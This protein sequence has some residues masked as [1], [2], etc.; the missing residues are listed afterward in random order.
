MDVNFWSA[1]FFGALAIC[2]FSAAVVILVCYRAPEYEPPADRRVVD[3]TWHMES[4][5]VVPPRQTI[6]DLLRREEL[7]QKSLDERTEARAHDLL[8]IL[9][10]SPSTPGYHACVVLAIDFL[11]SEGSEDDLEYLKEMIEEELEKC[12]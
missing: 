10:I 8:E 6:Q 4:R 9:E 1:V 12:R 2:S 11:W 3:T 5:R 7:D